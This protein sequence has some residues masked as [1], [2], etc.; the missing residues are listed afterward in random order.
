ME[1]SN[2][3]YTLTIKKSAAILNGK[4]NEQV[5]IKQSII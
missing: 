4:K 1:L 2:F 3:I 5:K